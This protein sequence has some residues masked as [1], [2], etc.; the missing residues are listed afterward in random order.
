MGE[1]E[2]SES[3]EVADG[4]SAVADA[5]GDSVYG[6][7]L[8]ADQLDQLLQAVWFADVSLIFLLAAVLLLCGVVL[9]VI[10]TKGWR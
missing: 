7:L 8:N 1:E 9:A 3:L 10:L 6:V 4:I 2:I 5:G